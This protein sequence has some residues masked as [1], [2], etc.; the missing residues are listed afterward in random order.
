MNLRRHLAVLQRYRWIVIV[1]GLLGVALAILAVFRVGSDGLSWRANQTWASNSTLYVTQR[2]FPDGRVVLG[3]ATSAA[4][5]DS[6][7]RRP[8]GGND[9]FA[10]P[11]RF[12]NLAIVYT[13]FA[14]SDEV[15]RVI[16]PK[17]T[18]DQLVMTPAPAAMNSNQTL[19]ILTLTTR[20]STPAKA[21]QLNAAAITALRGYLERQQRT[22][23]VQVRN[24]VRIDVLNP[25]SRAKLEAGHSL[26]PAIV[27]FILAMAGALALA[28][29]LDN[30]YP[31]AAREEPADLI[32]AGDDDDVGPSG[33]PLEVWPTRASSSRMAAGSRD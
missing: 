24:R 3:D 15:R 16:D 8:G 21:T 14:Q 20:A 29:C 31:P 32:D 18:A 30:L 13:Y 7:V 33:P 5:A 6:A 4:K 10:D 22:N 17:L 2:G 11:T 28:Y 1:G 19:P 23:G 27:A 9:E 25:P 26:T 12:A